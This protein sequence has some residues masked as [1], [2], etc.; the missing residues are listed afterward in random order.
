MFSFL[1]ISI[2]ALFFPGIINRTRSI[3]S[4]RK[5]PGIFQ[6]LKNIALL[7]RKG[8]VFSTS[9]SIITQFAP[10]LYLATTIVAALLVPFGE[11]SAF[12]SFDG[13]FILFAYL[14]ALGRIALILGAM[15][16]ASSFEGMGASREALY[17]TLVEPAFFILMGA[18]ALITGH[19][20]FESVFAQ[21]QTGGLNGT[22]L[23]ILSTFVLFGVMIVETCRVPVDDPRTHLELTM[24]HEVMI[25]DNSGFDL[26]LIHITTYL[27]FA[28]FSALIAACLIPQSIAFV[29][30][31]SLFF[32]IEAVCAVA[33][34]IL[35]SFRARY[36]LPR[37]ASYMVT[38]TAMAF[39]AFI[40]AAV[41]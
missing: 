20:S 28:V 35:E 7:L 40:T 36:R 38:I 19:T 29:W 26:G 33:I 10:T 13:D 37:N 11:Y 25:L 5:G 14:L 24:V 1:L 18:F 17:A 34:G 21:F 31:M 8:S 12:I 16:A 2:C 39:V 22:I 3:A 15:D 30:Q 41:I 27:K 23:G 4:G 6:P 32:V 9:S